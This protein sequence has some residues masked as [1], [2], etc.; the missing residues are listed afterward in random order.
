[1][2]V[3]QPF[4]E[5]QKARVKF[6]QAVA[7]ASTRPQNIEVMNN[8]TGILFVRL[9]TEGVPLTGDQTSASNNLDLDVRY[10]DMNGAAIDVSKLTQGTDF[11]AVVSITNPGVRGYYTQMALTQIFPSGWQIHNTRMDEAESTVKSDY[12]EYQDIRD[13]RVY[14]YFGISANTE[15][16][17]RIILNAS[18]TGKFYLPTVACEAMYDN[19]VNARKPG[20]WVEV[21]KAD[22]S[23]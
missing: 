11:I 21:V 18:F 15:K 10:T 2:S 14:T 23:E 6:S 1:M 7:D 4:E 9:I 5:Y 16:T 3:L 17:F 19:S 20:K 12:P 22:Q 13:D 8:G